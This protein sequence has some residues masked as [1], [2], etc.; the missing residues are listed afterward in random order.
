MSGV[1]TGGSG[2]V[3]IEQV[4][5]RITDWH[6][7][8]VRIEPLEGGITNTSYRVDVDGHPFVVRIPGAST[9]LLGVDRRNEHH[10]ARAAARVGVGPRVVRYLPD[11]HVTIVEFIEGQPMT[12][13]D[14]RAPGMP[15]RLA[16]SLRLLHAGPRFLR[17]FS[18]FRL[19]DRYLGVADARGIP[20]PA[21]YRG[22]LPALRRIEEV[23]ATSATVP[24]HND[25][26]AGNVIDDGRLL[27]FVDYEYSGNN[28]PAFEL[29]NMC[30]ELDYGEREIAELCTAYFG[31]A[32]PDRLARIRLHMITSD[33][34]WTLWAAIQ[35]AVSRIEFDFREYGA[36]RWA[37]AEAAMD[38]P[39]L[40]GWLDA[41][42]REETR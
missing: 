11:T 14:L 32:T 28:D 24:C 5:A 20:V 4:V 18:M 40:A 8:S 2:A 10:N 22:R 6:G 27:R 31:V 25:L 12:S 13:A 19:V 33:A 26:L 34:G 23:L 36:A 7:R 9:E 16:R 35:A 15:S 1:L 29:G 37:R 3:T 38:S 41:V 30:R 17:D 21:S 39:D 42:T